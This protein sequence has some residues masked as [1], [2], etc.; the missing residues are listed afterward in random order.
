MKTL[1]TLVLAVALGVSTSSAVLGQDQQRKQEQMHKKELVQEKKMSERMNR[2]EMMNK[3]RER[4]QEMMKYRAEMRPIQVREIHRAGGFDWGCGLWILA[5][6][7]TT[8]LIYRN[9]ENVPVFKAV[10]VTL[11]GWLSLIVWVI[12][13]IGKSVPNPFYKKADVPQTKKQTKK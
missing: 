11:F 10:L 9:K 5:G 8:Y 6:L 13:N 12:A 1:L 4:R 3:F 7:F 2:S